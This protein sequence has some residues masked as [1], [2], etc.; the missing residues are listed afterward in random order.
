MSG[1]VIRLVSGAEIVW[2][3]NLWLEDLL[4]DQ[5]EWELPLYLRDRF[6]STYMC[7]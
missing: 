6:V 2:L 7:G 4:L 5:F 3:V 1:V